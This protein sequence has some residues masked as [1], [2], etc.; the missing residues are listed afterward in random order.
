MRMR[1]GSHSAIKA[2]G[3]RYAT[4]AHHVEGLVR[5][6]SVTGIPVPA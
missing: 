6:P 4:T 1:P 5:S 3:A 2:G